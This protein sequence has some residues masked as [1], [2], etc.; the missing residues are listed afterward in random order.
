MWYA[1]TNFSERAKP[2]DRRGEVYIRYG[3]PDYRSRAGKVAPPMSMDVEQIKERLAFDIYGVDMTGEV[4]RGPVY[5]VRQQVNPGIDAPAYAPPGVSGL[6]E[7]EV[8]SIDVT[9]DP[10][11]EFEELSPTDEEYLAQVYSKPYEMPFAEDRLR[12]DSGMDL[13]F[14]RWESWVYTGVAGGIEIVFTDERGGGRFDYAPIP[15]A[16]LANPD[17]ARRMARLVKHSPEA[18]M[19]RSVQEAPEH[20]LPG[21]REQF[22]DFYYD[23]A[24]FRGRNGK[25]R[26]E[27]YYGMPPGSLSQTAQG[28]SAWMLAGYAAA[29]FDPASGEMLQE[30][31]EA[32]YRASGDLSGRKGEFIPYQLLLEARPGTYELR[33][34]AKDLRTGRSGIYKERLEVADYGVDSLRM[35]DLVLSWSVSAE[36]GADRYRKGDF[37]VIPMPTKAYRRDQNPFVYYEIYNLNRDAFGQSQFR[38][39]YTIQ[40]TP[41]K[42]KGFGRFLASVGQI[43]LRNREPEVSVSTE[44]ARSETDLREYFELNLQEAKGGV[45]R[46]TVTVTDLTT[47]QSVQK[48]ALFRYDL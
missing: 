29:L 19:K 18:T 28:D 9:D 3:P 41:E 33:V 34:Q 10:M 35:S 42:G 22:L 13:T 40:S 14:V 4:H 2:W 43:F 1:R 37:W 47:G 16:N 21:G 27:I 7:G 17:E 6:T 31:E 12:M 48:E 39:K 30:N 11:L 38:L 46:L 32:A 8:S 25:T 36:G 44:Q 24:N 5:P 15:A 23:R 26:L 20:Y 45:N